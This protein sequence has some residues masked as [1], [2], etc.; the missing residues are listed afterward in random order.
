[1]FLFLISVRSMMRRMQ[2]YDS[3]SS[4][5]GYFAH[6]RQR[7]SD[8][9]EDFRWSM[10]FS[11]TRR[12]RCRASISQENTSVWIPIMSDPRVLWRSEKPISILQR[13]S[14]RTMSV[15]SSCVRVS[16]VSQRSSRVM[17]LLRSWMP[18]M[19]GMNI[20]RRHCSMCSRWWTISRQIHSKGRSWRSSE[21]SDIHEYSALSYDSS[22]DTVRLYGSQLH[23]HSSLSESSDSGSRTSRVSKQHS[24]RRMSST[25]YGYRKSVGRDDL[26]RHFESIRKPM[27]SMNDDLPLPKKV[28]SSCILVQW[29]E[30][31][32]SCLR[33]WLVIRSHIS[34]NRSRM[35]WPW[36]RRFSGSLQS[37]SMVG[38]SRI[39]SSRSSDRYFIL[40]PVFSLWISLYVTDMW[41]IQRMG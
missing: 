19:G 25:H 28:Q 16:Q 36:E 11:R 37:V 5:R 8:S 38:K 29:S 21:I 1:M 7:S 3:Y 23:W 12:E 10:R 31:S 39:P 33:S 30:I 9:A 41:S 18:E 35:A 22:A 24:I 15:L 20:R 2:I 34:S 14:T 17:S 13:R 40:L 26:S 27:G 6:R 4:S 32:I